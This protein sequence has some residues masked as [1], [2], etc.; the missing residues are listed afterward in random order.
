[1]Q[2]HVHHLLRRDAVGQRRGHERAG[3]RADVDVE[4]VDRAVH[5]QQVKRAQRADLV[6][7]AGEAAAAE[8]ERRARPR[9]APARPRLSTRG[10]SLT[11]GIELDDVVHAAFEF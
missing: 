5:R 6:D 1:M 7:A 9:P 4:L 2:E 3:A 10:G 11:A 8:D